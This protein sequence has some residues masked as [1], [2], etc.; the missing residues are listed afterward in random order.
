MS[1]L[2]SKFFDDGEHGETASKAEKTDSNSKEEAG[3]QA[4]APRRVITAPVITSDA[5]AP[6]TDEEI[7]IKA[8]VDD[9][10]FAQCSFCVNQM[11][12]PDYSAWMPGAESAQAS[13]LAQKIFQE[14]GVVSVLIHE[15]EVIVERHDYIRD[16]WKP[17]A[18]RIGQ[19]IREHLKSGEPAIDPEFVKGIPPENEIKQK[20]DSVL[21]NELNPGIAAHGG[22]IELLDIKNNTIW[23][24]MGGG[25]QGCAASRITLK[26][27][28]H[29]AFRAA[30]PELGGIFDSTNH[31]AGTNP[32]FASLPGGMM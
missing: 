20:L 6:S 25:C 13:P 7:R 10:D 30:V 29:A 16:Q 26:Q 15:A 1:K 22:F 19:I 32:F 4:K 24:K 18:R 23:I 21:E 27:G 2:F 5:D 31:A 17:L 11:L 8:R 3:A 14:D 9:F 28:V 12:L